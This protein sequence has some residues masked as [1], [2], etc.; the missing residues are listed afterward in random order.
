MAIYS[1]GIT[2]IGIINIVAVRNVF[3]LLMGRLPA[4]NASSKHLAREYHYVVIDY[5]L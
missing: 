4:F 3:V 5:N 1:K 2:I